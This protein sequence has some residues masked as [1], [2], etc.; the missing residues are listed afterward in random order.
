[1]RYA[2]PRAHSDLQAPHDRIGLPPR[3]VNDEHQPCTRRVVRCEYA[4]LEPWRLLHRGREL[5]TQPLDASVAVLS[6]VIDL[7]QYAKHH[8][9]IPLTS[10]HSNQLMAINGSST[11][12]GRCWTIWTVHCGDRVA[13]EH[14]NGPELLEATGS[15]AARGQPTEQL[16]F[17]H[18]RFRHL[19]RMDIWTRACRPR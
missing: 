12:Q 1:D 4:G 2:W 17:A 5:L 18:H 15:W 3:F 19:T 6:A 13:V 9:A 14:T 10:S 11:R 16:H 7:D 8:D